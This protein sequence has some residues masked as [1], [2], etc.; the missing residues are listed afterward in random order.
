M[1]ESIG[2]D[3]DFISIKSSTKNSF[4]NKFIITAKKQKKYF[5]IRF[6]RLTKAEKRKEGMIILISILSY[7][8]YYLSLGGCD[9]TQ[10]ECLKNS[11]IAYYYLLVN[12][13]FSS[14]GIVSFIIFMMWINYSCMLLLQTLILLLHHSF[15][16]LQRY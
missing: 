12:Y 6:R 11:N 10:T 3:S 14:A 13:C 5:F 2:D 16:H 9:G 1:S 4:F 15:H 7:V 8:L